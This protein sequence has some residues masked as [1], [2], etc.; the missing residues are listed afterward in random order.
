[1]NELE[2]V[3]NSLADKL[4]DSEMDKLLS[5]VE[6]EILPLKSSIDE[7]SSENQQLTELVE[8][9]NGSD[10]ELR[11]AQMQKEDN[12]KEKEEL[13][14]LERTLIADQQKLNSERDDLDN[15]ESDYAKRMEE[16]NR[17][18]NDQETELNKRLKG[19]KRAVTQKLEK[20][21]VNKEN[22]LKKAYNKKN[23]TLWGVVSFLCAASIIPLLGLIISVEE[24]RGDFLRF[25][26]PLK[27]FSSL[28]GKA[29]GA[30]V[31]GYIAAIVL[32]V[33]VLMLIAVLCKVYAG[34]MP[35]Y[36]Q[37]FC[38]SLAVFELLLAVNSFLPTAYNPF[39]IGLVLFVG[40]MGAT[41]W[42][43]NK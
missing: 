35:L 4:N 1:M 17:I 6:N 34:K 8:M 28:I 36:K 13:N 16:Y 2:N 9:L 14:D 30:A 33:F 31:V 12:R 19:H 25:L 15:R 27:A 26:K 29:C 37:Y 21:Y 23:K 3:L 5:A 18:H 32:A 40:G 42:M 22:D 24:N 38:G 43:S 10:K 41:I 20:E 11:Q 39:W 7:L